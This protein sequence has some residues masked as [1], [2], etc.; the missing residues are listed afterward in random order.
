[1]VKF[2]LIVVVF[3]VLWM[4][5][6]AKQRRIKPRAQD[7]PP[8]QPEAMPACAHCGVHLPQS[9]VLPGRGGV[10]CSAAHRSAYEANHPDADASQ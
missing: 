7:T 5:F 9:L 6:S 4:M 1:M 8:K 3:V 2:L 10:F